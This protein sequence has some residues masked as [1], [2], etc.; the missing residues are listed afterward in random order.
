[1]RARCVALLV[2]VLA[3]PAA[4][5][6]PG[7]GPAVVCAPA[8]LID[9]DFPDP[10]LFVDPAP[11]GGVFAYAT[12][13][14]APNGGGMLNVPFSR[15]ADP[16]LAHWSAPA[17]A[18][19]RLP[20]WAQPGYTWA[21]AVAHRPGGPYRLY[22]TARY[23][24]SGRPCVGVAVADS[25]A[26]PFTPTDDVRPLVCPLGLGGA[27]DPDVFREDDGGEYLLW[28]T[29]SNCC[30]GGPEIYIQKLA[31]DGLSLVGP[32]AAD[33]PWLLA[34][35]V[36]LLR[37]DQP[38]EGRV[39]EAPSLRK[40]DGR[41]VLFYS[42]G[43]YASVGYAVGYAVSDSLLGPYRKAAAPILATTD[44]GLTGP[45]GEMV[46]TGPDGGD[47]M[48]FHGWRADSGRTYRAFYLGRIDWASGLPVVR[49]DCAPP[50]EITIEPGRR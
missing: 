35:A 3:A 23:G 14:A 10:D 36:S 1:M 47:W 50:P 31:A 21:P 45:G 46:F 9:A 29:D 28:K 17:E 13:A 16:A 18:L 39:V 15:S 11:G 40:H 2:A 8:P 48:A 25:P 24:F 37:R 30:D 26:G 7:A 34:D 5:T 49:T 19:P 12:N 4:A 43:F 27:I 33:G 22:F 38:W 6:E 42:G 44:A 41:Y 32:H 20:S